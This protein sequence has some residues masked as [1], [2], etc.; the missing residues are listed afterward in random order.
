MYIAQA[1]GEP[2]TETVKVT[3]VVHYTVPHVRTGIFTYPRDCVNPH[4]ERQ[5]VTKQP[6]LIP[7]SAGSVEISS[8]MAPVNLAL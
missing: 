1:E 5:V 2:I 6:K 3:I 7:G 4:L 8:S